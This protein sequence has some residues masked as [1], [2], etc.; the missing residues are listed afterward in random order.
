MAPNF[1]PQC[2]KP[3]PQGQ[4]LQNGNPRVHSAVPTTRRVSDIAR[5]QRRLLSNPYQSKLKEVPP[6]P[7]SG[8]NLV[9]LGCPVWPLYGSY[10]VYHCGQGGKAHGSDKKYPNASVPGQLV[11][12]GKRQGYMFPG[13]PNPSGFVPRVRLGSE[14]QKSE[15]EPKQVFNFIGYQY[16]LVKGI[17]RPT[18]ERWEALNS[19][20][21]SLLPRTSCSVRQLMS[22]IGLLT[23]TKKAGFIW[24]S[25]QET[26]SLVPEEPLAHPKVVGEDHPYSQVPSSSLALVVKGRKCPTG[27]ALAPP[28]SGCSDLYRDI[29]RR[30]GGP[31]RRLYR[32]AQLVRSG[33][34]AAYQFPS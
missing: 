17:V 4:N 2:L 23:A 26:H 19:K 34:Q 1:T 6:V 33:K 28:L 7:L 29:K 21:N 32:K 22:L 5:L 9:V 13:H 3:F 15:L 12:P 18:P 24:V 10:G 27:P 14:P 16:D 20:I 11:D 31:F 8:P 25:T 30:L